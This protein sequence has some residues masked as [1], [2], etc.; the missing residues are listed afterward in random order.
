MQGVQLAR[1]GESGLGQG[2]GALGR[3]R[4]CAELEHFLE[5]APVRAHLRWHA[6]PGEAARWV[7][8]ESRGALVMCLITYSRQAAL[9]QARLPSLLGAGCSRFSCAKQTRWAR[10][11]GW[12]AGAA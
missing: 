2:L 12:P 7:K 8:S 6:D 4:A 9:S 3:R 10:P 11:Q 1:A 5:R